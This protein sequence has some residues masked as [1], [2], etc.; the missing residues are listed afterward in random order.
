MYCRS[1]PVSSSSRHQAIKAC[2]QAMGVQSLQSTGPYSSLLGVPPAR[3]QIPP[4]LSSSS[5]SGSHGLIA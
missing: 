2:V 4:L 5:F 1:E 3:R